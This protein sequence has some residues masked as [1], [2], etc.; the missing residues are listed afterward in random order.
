MLT[1]H[2]PV[3]MLA[4]L[5]L[6]AP[7]ASAQDAAPKKPGDPVHHALVQKKVG[8]YA[9]YLPPDYHAEANAKKRWP[10]CVILHGHGSSETGHGGLS[11]TF[12]RDG[13]IYLAPRAPHA[14]E[15]MFL[16]NKTPGWTAWPNYPKS[17]GAHDSPG[18]PRDETEKL[19]IDRL[20]TDWIAECIADVRKRYRI[21]GQRPVVVGHSQGAA[22]AHI[23]S[24]HR[25]ELVRAYFAYAGYY[26]D[27]TKDAIAAET[28]K[29]HG[30]R[31]TLYHCEG[32]AVVNA[33]ETR[34][35]AKYLTDHGVEHEAKIVPKGSHS[36]TSSVTHAARQFVAQL[37]RGEEPKPLEGIF[38]VTKVLPETQ[39]ATIGLK[40]G[41]IILT[42]AGKKIGN[43]DDLREVLTASAE[44]NEPISLTWRRGTEEMKATLEPGRIGVML[45]DR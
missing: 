32:D 45:E 40:A 23:L 7:L 4:L 44:S 29:K 19:A 39:G 16:E 20:Y 10:L 6:L 37:C 33:E 8:F 5:V 25:P 15:E 21:D 28:L 24:I 1:S 12:G 36:F 34:G 14:H 26:R 11:N 41:D 2:R 3:L 31:P 9:V 38:V 13:V 30:I 17:W 35:L 22:Y 42:Y 27:T 43:V 18:F